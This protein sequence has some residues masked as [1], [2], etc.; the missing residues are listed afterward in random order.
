M[1]FAE[2]KGLK[3][4]SRVYW[5][6]DAEDSGHILQKSVG[7]RSRLPGT[8]VTWPPYTMVTCAKSNERRQSGLLCKGSRPGGLKNQTRF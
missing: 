5:R 4:G 2:S 3:K 1:T 8:M 7:M 6:G